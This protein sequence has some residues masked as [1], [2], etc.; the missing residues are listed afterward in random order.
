M[1]ITMTLT[2]TLC[3]S[4]PLRTSLRI[5][6]LLFPQLQ[7]FRVRLIGAHFMLLPSLA[8]KYQLF[9]LLGIVSF[10]LLSTNCNWHR[11]FCLLAT[12]HSLFSVSPLMLKGKKFHP[13]CRSQVG[14]DRNASI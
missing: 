2:R 3:R 13:F 6:C 1:I 8:G 5:G 4:Q 11:F 14:V 9:L 7:F 10:S 12:E